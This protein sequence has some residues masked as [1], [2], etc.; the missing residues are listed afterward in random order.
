MPAYC[1]AGGKAILATL[2]SSALRSLYPGPRLEQMTSLS[3]G[4]FAALEADL[5]RTRERGYALNFGE[6]ES[7]VGAVAMALPA[8]GGQPPAA[9]TVSAPISRLTEESARHIADTLREAISSIA[10]SGA[11]PS[12]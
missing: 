7:E 1:T 4:S 8:M 6:S 11:T 12:A 5:E 2:P 10:E 3:H 9:I